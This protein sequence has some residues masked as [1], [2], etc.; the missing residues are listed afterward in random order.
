MYIYYIGVRVQCSGGDSMVQS[1]KLPCTL[2]FTP[3]YGTTWTKSSQCK[4][5]T[6][7]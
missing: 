1:A 6:F 2:L 3:I 5:H 7:V 4:S